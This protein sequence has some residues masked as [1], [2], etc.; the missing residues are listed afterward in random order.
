[1]PALQV[2]D[3]PQDLYD[4]LK[5]CAAKEDRSISQQTVHILRDYLRAYRQWSNR[6]DWEVIPKN[7]EA[8]SAYHDRIMTRRESEEV[9]RQARIEKRKKIFEKIDKLP[10][11]EVP[12]DFPSP[13]ELVRQG[14]EERDAQ[15]FEALGG[16]R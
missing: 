10:H 9:E 3:F 13:A 16:L 6:S 5:A 1:M 11:F 8:F 2:K 15:I 14:R 12:D 7:S 4:E